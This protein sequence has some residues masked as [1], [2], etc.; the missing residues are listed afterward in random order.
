M[1]IHAGLASKLWLAPLLIACY[2]TNRLLT[3]ALE[4][5]TPFKAWYKRKLEISNLR[6]YNCDVYVVDY[7]AEAQRKM[8]PRSMAGILV[9]YKAK[10]QWRIWNNTRIFVRRD[11]IFNESKFWYKNGT[12]SEPVGEDTTTDLV[13]LAGIFQLLGE[14][15]HLSSIQYNDQTKQCH[16]ST[17]EPKGNPNTPELKDNGSYLSKDNGSDSQ[18]EH[19]PRPFLLENQDIKNLENQKVNDIF[20]PVNQLLHENHEVPKGKLPT[21]EDSDHENLLILHETWRKIRHDY[22]QL[23]TRGFAKAAIF[24]NPYNI[25]TP[26]SYKEAIAGLQAKEWYA[27]YRS[28]YDSQIAQSIFTITRLFYDYKAIEGKGVFKLKENSDR[29]IERYK[30]RWVAKRY[31]QVQSHDYEKTYAPV[32]CSDASRILLVISAKL[33]WKIKQFDIDTVFLYGSMDRRL[34][35]TQPQ[36]FEQGEG[37]VWLLNIA[38][39]RLV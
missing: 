19:S 34:Y 33:G 35:T 8:A 23:N 18:N 15:Y 1:L 3:K 14:G 22:K 6:V 36:G 39:Y 30:A 5:K 29:S 27:A 26:K 17:P 10:N 16:P 11:V 20:D 7:K 38:I 2:I 9:G 12:S 28:E 21:K 37:F 4:Q 32:V 24:V 13:N 31:W 25:V